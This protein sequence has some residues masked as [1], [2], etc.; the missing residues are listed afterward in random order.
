MTVPITLANGTILVYGWGY[1][2]GLSGII[3]DN[4]IILIILANKFTIL[5]LAMF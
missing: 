1:D 3:P 4:L 2:A 5:N